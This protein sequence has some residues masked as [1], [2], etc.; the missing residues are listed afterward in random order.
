MVYLSR[1]CRRNL[2]LKHRILVGLNITDAKLWAISQGDTTGAT[3][4]PALVHTCQ[5]TGYLLSRRLGQSLSPNT[6]EQENYHQTLVLDSLAELTANPSPTASLQTL[7][8]LALYFMNKGDLPLSRQV[9]GRASDAVMETDLDLELVDF[10]SSCVRPQ[11]VTMIISPTTVVGENLAA[12]SQ[13]VYLD[14][15]FGVV[16][17]LPSLLHPRLLESF[18]K[19]VVS[20]LSSMLSHKLNI[21]FRIYRSLPTRKL[22]SSVPRAS[23]SS[24]KRQ[25]LRRN[26]VEPVLVCALLCFL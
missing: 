10:A 14:M 15:K 7:P 6:C 12:F 11:R 18:K 21:F 20:T 16:K 3:V 5:L 2:C 22:T 17:N 9:L 4:H 13:L 26:G 1:P 24:V 25:N 8:L 19:L 23:F